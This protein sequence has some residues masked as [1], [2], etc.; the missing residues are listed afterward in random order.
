MAAKKYLV[1][2]KVP[3]AFLATLPAI[4][5][6]TPRSKVKKAIADEAK[7]ANTTF[8]SSSGVKDDPSRLE[9][10][11]KEASSNLSHL[12]HTSYSSHLSSLPKLHNLSAPKN[13]SKKWGRS[14]RN[15]KTF[16][17]FK[18]SVKNWVHED[19]IEVKSEAATALAGP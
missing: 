10:S 16:T 15:F 9:A 8:K 6:P 11:M 14:K 12:S 17:G 4:P 3:S 19:Q 13:P 1:L 7:L 18:F 5:A 2:V